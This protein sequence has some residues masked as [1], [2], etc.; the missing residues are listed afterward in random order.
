[1]GSPRRVWESVSMGGVGLFRRASPV[2]LR[3]L[4]GLLGEVEVT[5]L[6]VN[7][8]CR[9]AARLRPACQRSQ[10]NHVRQQQSW[11]R[12]CP[13]GSGVSRPCQSMTCRRVAA[14]SRPGC[15]AAPAHSPD[16]CAPS[17][18]VLG[19]VPDSRPAS[20]WNR[21]KSVSPPTLDRSPGG[22]RARGACPST[23]NRASR[24]RW[25]RT[26][27]RPRVQSGRGHPKSADSSR[28]SLPSGGSSCHAH[29]SSRGAF[30][31]PE[32]STL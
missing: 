21:S 14:P 22:R 7:P 18:W 12:Y 19:R 2:L 30:R 8:A 1:M 11:Q 23:T 17:R 5:F 13:A 26:A 29:L 10:C 24:T 31:S 32:P 9:R 28:S 20:R 16:P 25:R 27:R 3:Q 15:R 6:T 4:P